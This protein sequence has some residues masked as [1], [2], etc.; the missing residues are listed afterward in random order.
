MQNNKDFIRLYAGEYSKMSSVEAFICSV[1]DEFESVA[2]IISDTSER[3]VTVNFSS[4][5]NFKLIID[6]LLEHYETLGMDVDDA[7]DLHSLVV[8]TSDPE[9]NAYFTQKRMITNQGASEAFLEMINELASDS[10]HLQEFVNRIDAVLTLS[11]TY[12]FK[13]FMQLI[14]NAFEGS[15]VSVVDAMNS[16]LKHKIH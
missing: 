4:S 9:M 5:D 14:A 1:V 12:Q 8:Y 10:A 3:T 13:Q 7:V 6:T 15:G 11:G 2:N 16:L